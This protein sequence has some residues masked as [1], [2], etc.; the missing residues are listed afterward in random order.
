MK[1]TISATDAVR[2]FSEVVNRVRYRGDTF[3]VERGGEAV[4]RIE[5]VA[6]CAVSVADLVALLHTAPAADQGFADEVEAA[7]SHQ[8]PMPRSPWAR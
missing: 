5:P 1:R 2:T 7:A 8:P 4:C 3:I 6:P